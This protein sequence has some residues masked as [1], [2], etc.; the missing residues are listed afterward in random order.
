MWVKSGTQGLV[1]LVGVV[2]LWVADAY[3]QG[4]NPYEL[5]PSLH[6][7][8]MILCYGVGIACVL[9]AL[10]TGIQALWW[11]LRRYLQGRGR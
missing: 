5:A 10:V 6:Q 4:W 1:F 8:Q 7:A 9:F 11:R 2:S 3:R